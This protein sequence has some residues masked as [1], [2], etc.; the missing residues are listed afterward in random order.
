MRARRRRLLFS[1]PTGGPVTV[2]SLGLVV[3]LLPLTVPAAAAAASGTSSAANTIA[4]LSGT[5]SAGSTGDGGQATSAELNSPYGVTAAHGVTYIADRLNHR[6]RRVDAAGVI[7]TIA[8][9]GT[10]GFSGDDGDAAG[11]QLNQPRGLAMDDEGNLYVADTFNNRVRRIDPLGVITTVA[12]DGTAGYAGDGD[13]ATSAELASPASVAV[14]GNGNLYIADQGNQRIRMVAAS[15]GVIT[16]VAGTGVAGYSGDTGPAPAARLNGPSGVALDAQGRVYVADSGNHRVR[17][18]GT[19]GVISTFAGTGSIGSSGD[20]GAATAAQLSFPAAV[21]VDAVGQVVIADRGNNRIRLVDTSGQITTIAGSGS[22]GYS[23]DGGPATQAQLSSPYG[24]GVGDGGLVYIADTGNQRVRRLDPVVAAQGAL[25]GP[26]GDLHLIDCYPVASSAAQILARPDVVSAEIAAENSGRPVEVTGLDDATTTTFVKPDGSFATAVAAGPIRV[27]DSA[28][29]YQPIDLTLAP[30]TPGVSTA[31]PLGTSIAPQVSATHIGFS[32]GGVGTTAAL[33]VTPPGGAP[34]SI[35]FGWSSPLPTPS[36]AGAVATYANVLPVAAPGTSMVLRATATGFDQSLVLTHAPLVPLKIT[37]PLNL[38]PG[39]QV[40]SSPDGAFRFVDPD[41]K[42]LA[43]APE[44]VVYGAPV[45]QATGLPVQSTR[46]PVQVVNSSTG[47]SLQITPPMSFLTNPATTYPVVID[48]AT[49]LHSASDTWVENDYSSNQNGSTELREGTWGSDSI[50]RSLLSFNVSGLK[51]KDVLS[52]TLSVYQYH[53]WSCSAR[54][55]NL[56]RVTSAWDPSTVSYS[57]ASSGTTSQPSV[58]TSP[59]ATVNDAHG[60]SSSC[61]ADW[62]RFSSAGLASLIEGWANG[63]TANYGVELRAA[64]ETDTYA[65]KRFYST[66]NGSYVPT[67]TVNYD[68][69]PG[70][71][72]GR[73]VTPCSA[74]CTPQPITNDRTPVLTAKTTDPDGTPLRYDFEVW[75]GTSSSPT[76]RVASGSVSNVA[77]GATA[78]WSPPANLTDQHDFE[79][80]VRAYD[81]IDYGPWSTGW[82]VFHT[83]TV[84]PASPTVT[85]TD[86]P[87]GQWNV[88]GGSGSFTLSTTSTDLDAFVYQLDDATTLTPVSGSTLTFTPVNG[89]HTLVVYAR[90]KAGNLSAPTSYVFGVGAGITKP[91]DGT[92]TLASVPL[93]AVVSSAASDA[94]YQY[95]TDNGTN[96]SPI[97]LG[98]GAVTVASTSAALA[99]WPVTLT[100]VSATTKSPIA[101]NW[102]LSTTL[103]GV[104]GSVKLRACFTGVSACTNEITVQLDQNAF[105]SAYAT[106]SAGPG[107]VSLLT[108]NYAIDATD[109]SVSGNLA[110]LSVARTFNSRTPG[111]VGTASAPAAPNAQVFGPG[112]SA[113]LPEDDTGIDYTRLLDSGALVSV[114]SVDGSVLTF[115]R[116]ATGGYVPQLD[117]AAEGLRLTKDTA[118]PPA[119]TL[120]DLSGTQTVFKTPTACTP[121]ATGTAAPAGTYVLCGV[122]QPGS[123]KTTTYAFDATGHVTSELAPL[124]DGVSS[125]TTMVKGCRRLSLF[126]ATSTTATS[127]AL[128]DIS[129]QV[130]RVDFTAYDPATSAMRTVTM[131]TYQYDSTGRLRQ[132][133]DPRT[134]LGVAYTYDGNGRLATLTPPGQAA[135]TFGYDG[136][137]RFSTASRTP[138]GHAPLTWRVLYGVPLTKAAGGPIDMAASDVAT[139]GQ[140]DAPVTA[141]AAYGPDYVAHA[142]ASPVDYTG[143]MLTYIDVYGRAVNTATYGGPVNTDGSR[144]QVSTTEYDSNTGN[145]LRSLSASNRTL[146]LSD[147]SGT[148][149]AVVATYYDV[150]NRYDSTGTILVD[151]WGPLH[152]LA[153]TA[154]DGSLQLVMGRS[155]A[156]TVYDEGAPS[157][158]GPYQLPTTV[159]S[160]ASLGVDTVGNTQPDV[161]VRTTVNAYD[162]QSNLGWTLRSPTKVT[163]DPGTGTLN[164]IRTT[165]Y[166]AGTGQVVLTTLPASSAGT[167]AHATKTTYY[168]GSGTGTCGGHPEWQG[169]TCQVGPAGQP[170]TSADAPPVPTSTTTYTMWNAP[171]QIKEVVP[172]SSSTTRT[173]TL[174]YDAAGRQISSSIVTSPATGTAI[175]T[176]TTV[177]NAATGA[178]DGINFVDSSGKVTSS[179]SNL[180]DNVGRTT[181]YTDATGIITHTTYDDAGRVSSVNDGLGTTSYTYDSSSDLRGQVSKLVDSQAGQFTA[182]YDADGKLTQQSLPSGVTENLSYDAAGAEISRNYSHGSTRWLLFSSVSNSGGQI[183]KADS[184][185]SSQRYDYD[186]AGRLSH[187][188]D[189]AYSGTAKSCTVRDYSFDA[190]SNRASLTTRAPGAG[191][192]CD[193][194]SASQSPD[195]VNYSYDAADRLIATGVKYDA[196]GR[197]IQLP[198]SADDPTWGSATSPGSGAITNA[199]Y[200]NDLVASQTRGNRTLSWTLDPALRANAWTDTTSGSTSNGTTVPSTTLTHTQHYSGGGDSPA[201]TADSSSAGNTTSTTRSVT[202]LDGALAAQV[203]TPANGTAAVTYELGN[204]HGDVVATYTSTSSYGP[205]STFENTE[206]G[207]ARNT[208][209]SEAHRRYQWLGA[210]TRADDTL[211]GLVLM[212]VR[213]YSPTLGRFLQVDPVP[214]GSA[215]AYDYAG[216]DPINTFDL[217]GR[218][219]VCSAWHHIKKHMSAIVTVA[220]IASFIPVVGVGFAVVAAAG[221]AYMAADDFRHHRYLSGVLNAAGAVAGVGDAVMGIRA[222]RAARALE[223]ANAEYRGA[224]QAFRSAT[225]HYEALE[226]SARASRV[227]WHRASTVL[228]VYGVGS[229]ARHRWWD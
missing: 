108:G 1:A 144:W 164:L 132:V 29:D 47:T 83:D 136:N 61:D 86:Y 13:A 55:Q 174:G 228:S 65:W 42:L 208:T 52:A 134:N 24:V 116:T 184:T 102:N 66:N 215:N 172:D 107:A 64:D 196:F 62:S 122:I 109:A 7:T 97:P 98:T 36:L 71:A 78:K 131:A 14:D 137:G 192:A 88:T 194:T 163:T 46:V 4:T 197:T 203:T 156:H 219:W 33:T 173:T 44:S 151:T 99:S 135:W 95:S 101:L 191:G 121:G 115:A 205:D 152:Q 79:Y 37:I 141:A 202:G 158:G 39:V 157:S 182:L 222:A 18:I 28:G 50:A 82:M 220:S 31:L 198:T 90:D 188:E 216:A 96:W 170:A 93:A 59:V 114:T 94:T 221:S 229:Y 138:T 11:A 111:A 178:V 68:S 12:G 133:V 181:D 10:A 63:T 15:D 117:A 165:T 189:T 118:T 19:D 57:G 56:L 81:G 179:I 41:G 227:A 6:I 127:S 142:S 103:A 77:S 176:M 153:Y 30:A 110:T 175:P 162:G 60:Y 35:G 218:C 195:V 226:R 146:A 80:R 210:K 159:T 211:G 149:T 16:T 34:Q 199:F 129:G 106:T 74:V 100:T 43:S 113:T 85:S 104:D 145:V 161:D 32:N 200:V 9:T 69:Y 25:S 212:G 148:S 154:S 166:D 126:Y 105:G 120:S 209:T 204:P 87:S 67:L 21:A 2:V 53:S 84:K 168:T 5:G 124:P 49:S 180:Y 140:Q 48:P 70:T 40:V 73:S 20:L 45:D 213:L 22:A 185:L 91:G 207:A 171:A 217:D 130:S 72:A 128:G 76:V 169:L 8:G 51:G 125:C 187:V 160:G 17:V 38:P 119:W 27:L 225:S 112:W 167:D 183:R 75:D 201:W 58:N 193:P 147:T 89:W 177:Y 54:T 214:G 92:R 26:C 224:T 143:A 139:W 123:S 223:S 186:Q 206:F 23:G 190:D 150:Q 3:A 155:H